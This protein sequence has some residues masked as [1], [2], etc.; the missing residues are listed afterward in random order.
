MSSKDGRHGA[1]AGD[2]TDSAPKLGIAP[3]HE[4]APKHEERLAEERR[5]QEV[6]RT[7]PAPIRLGRSIS[8]LSRLLEQVASRSGLTLAQYRVLV[9]VSEAPHRASV[10]AAKIDV[11]RAT[12]SAIV[13]GLEQ[14]GLLERATVAGDRRGV[15]LHLT[16]AG[17]AA[18]VQTE[19]VLA[20]QLSQAVDLGGLDGDRAAED[21]DRLLTGFAMLADDG[22]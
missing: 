12:L 3:K 18:L 21:L 4:S 7:L 1:A 22:R 11:R 5:R 13:T 2:G 16:A 6:S 8:R 10:L 19:A 14:N 17:H 15:S 20:E 9:L